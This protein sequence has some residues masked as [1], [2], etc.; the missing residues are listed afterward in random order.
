MSN[1]FSVKEVVDMGIEKEKK[2]RDFYAMV[3]E[4]FQEQDLK[5]LFTKLRDWEAEHV[6]KFT[7]I[8]SELMEEETNERYPGELSDYIKAL[9]DD[10][11]YKEMTPE[12]FSKEISSPVSA[13]QRGMEFEKDAVLF[14]SELLQ[15]I[16]EG[17]KDVI[18][19]LIDEEKQ[20]LLYLY[21]LKSNYS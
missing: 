7:E 18:K 15:Y 2:R 21:Q 12:D 13:I 17:K 11:L 10:K 1:L 8:R 5:D 4:N 9:V 14:F 16:K 6:K 3:A 19:T 20:H